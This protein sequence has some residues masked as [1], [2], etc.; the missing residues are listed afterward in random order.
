VRRSARGK[1]VWTLYNS[2]DKLLRGELLAAAHRPV[3]RYHD[4]WNDKPLT[5][6]SLGREDLIT[7][8]IAPG[9]CGCIVQQAPGP[10]QQ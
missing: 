6:R 1:V 3:A 4:A 7:I 9:D 5:A 10:K 2:S 8:E